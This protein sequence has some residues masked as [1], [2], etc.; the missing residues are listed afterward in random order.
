M[1]AFFTSV[2]QRDNP[3]LRNKA[4][5]VGGGKRGVIAAASY[6][7]RKYGVYSAMPSVVALRKCPHLIFVKH[8]FEAYKKASRQIREIFNKYSN[9]VQ[10]LSLDEAYLDITENIAKHSS[11]KE[12]ALIIK[13]E[14]FA[15]TKLTASAGVSFNKFLA[16]IASDLNKPNGIAVITPEKAP[17]FI[18]KLA[19][20]K[21]YGIGK[22]TEQK[23]KDKGIFFGAD[24]KKYDKF[25]LVKMFGKSGKYFYD[26][27]NLL[28][29][30][31]VKEKTKNK[32]IGTE[33]TFYD[34]IES[35]GIIAMKLKVIAKK[36]IKTLHK[37][38]DKVKTIT[39]KIKYSDFVLKTRSK[40]LTHYTWSEKEIISICLILLKQEELLKPIRLL[41]VSLSN[42]E[43][44]NKKGKGQI[45]FDF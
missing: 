8:N 9:F 5:A 42:F 29:E 40:T 32:S 36:I 11:A 26:I 24:L 33:S 35:F 44:E 20:G 43:S 17:D 2:E 22:V 28:D 15:K 34:D 37:G 39:I 25:Q 3:E 12:T 41:G 45:L 38:D 27:V 13:Q 23:M 4:I 10:P 6:E 18:D 19:I 30:R 21:F 7:A 1:D 16:K 31:P 14:I